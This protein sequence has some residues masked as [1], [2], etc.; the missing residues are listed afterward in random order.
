MVQEWQWRHA[1]NVFGDHND[2]QRGAPICLLLVSVLLWQGSIA[3]ALRHM[4]S[5]VVSCHKV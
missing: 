3:L 1:A 5:L 4:G 2:R